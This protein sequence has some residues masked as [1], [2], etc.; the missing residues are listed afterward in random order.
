MAMAHTEHS[1]SLDVF[2]DHGEEFRRFR[3]KSSI[4]RHGKGDKKSVVS[5]D[6]GLNVRVSFFPVFSCF[7]ARNC[8]SLGIGHA[9]IQVGLAREAS[10]RSADEDRTIRGASLLEKRLCVASA[11][12]DSR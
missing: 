11:T 7:Q 5:L 1:G 6:N 2:K 8:S 3:S 4:R 9:T 12:F 10:N